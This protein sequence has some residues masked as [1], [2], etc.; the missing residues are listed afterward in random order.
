MTKTK[1]SF[2]KH[3]QLKPVSPTNMR[4]LQVFVPWFLG[5]VVTLGLHGSMFSCSAV[6]FKTIFN[7]VWLV[8]CVSPLSSVASCHTCFVLVITLFSIYTTQFLWFPA[9]SSYFLPYFTPFFMFLHLR[10]L[11]CPVVNFLASFALQFVALISS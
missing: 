10:Y 7:L 6:Y 11:L 2:R 5:F 1:K 8:V 3:I 4:R 9:R